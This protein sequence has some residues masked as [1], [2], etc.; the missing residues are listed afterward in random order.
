V[1]LRRVK[2]AD[3]YDFATVQP[4]LPQGWFSEED[5]E[6]LEEFGFEFDRSPANETIYFYVEEGAME[7]GQAYSMFQSKLRQHPEHEIK[8]IVVECAYTCSRM[9]PGE[10]GG[11]VVR[12]T[13]D[14]IDQRSTQDILQQLRKE[15]PL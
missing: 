7:W 5:L 9:C 12:I 3:N 4:D 1:K 10:F 2:V 6:Q 8:E 14:R 13:K 15:H 11:W